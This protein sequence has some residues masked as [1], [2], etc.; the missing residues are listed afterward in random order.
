MLLI[1]VMTICYLTACNSAKEDKY[2]PI[3]KEDKT[4]IKD[5]CK[6]IEPL[7]P[8]IEKLANAK[9]SMEATMYMDSLMIKSNEVTPCSGGS[10]ML[11]AKAEKDD[12]YTKQMIAYIEQYYPKCLPFFLGVKTKSDIKN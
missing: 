10:E 3:T 11:E 9:D 5:L 1:L 2:D 7:T 8:Y 6:C 12:N 4:L